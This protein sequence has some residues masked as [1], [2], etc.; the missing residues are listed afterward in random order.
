MDGV[1]EG[2]GSYMYGSGDVFEGNYH[3]NQRHGPGTLKK[4]DGEIREE[5]WKEDKLVSYNTIKEKDAK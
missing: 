4:V 5:T 3:N 2:Q 1:K